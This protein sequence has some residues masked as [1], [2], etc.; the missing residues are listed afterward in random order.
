MSKPPKITIVRHAEK[1]ANHGQPHGV[2]DTGDPDSESLIVQGWQR[3]GALVCLFAPTNVSL[4]N[5][6]LARPEFLFASGIGLDSNSKRPQ[7]TITP[8]SKK[9]KLT[10]N[11]DFLKGQEKELTKSVLKCTGVVL[12]CWEHHKIPEIVKHIVGETTTF[13][14]IW[15]DERFDMVWVLDLDAESGD[16][17]FQ[18]VSQNLLSGDSSTPFSN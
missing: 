17:R 4:Q 13:P 11:T 18:Q 7:Q 2:L 1:P 16:Y 5:P 6:N 10:I 9:L 8:L 14:S 3:A 15:P 12:I